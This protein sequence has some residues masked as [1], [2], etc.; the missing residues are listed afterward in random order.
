MAPRYAWPLFGLASLPA[1]LPEATAAARVLLSSGA[2]YL[3]DEVS[4]WP[5]EEPPWV[6]MAVVGRSNVGKSSLL[7][8]LLGS[9]DNKFVPVS[10]HPGSTRH[11][12]FYGVGASG[13]APPPFVFVDSP[14]YGYNSHGK[15]AQ[16]AWFDLIAAYL[17]RRNPAILPRTLLLLDASVGC[18]PTDAAVLQLFDGACAPYH[19]V[20]TK[21][22]TV[23]PAHLEATVATLA[24][25]LARRA[26]P[27]P[28]IN[29]VSTRTGAGMSTLKEHLMMSAKVYRRPDVA[30]TLAAA[31][32]QL[33][34]ARKH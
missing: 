9:R 18:T 12:D 3:G 4:H 5:T 31:T 1:V 23:T 32:R 2:R 19:V 20:L 13:S 27:F 11:L 8:A 22:D 10:R 7:N 29:A 6:E 15:R 30:A 28:I 25:R 17:R 33:A 16:D 14:G 21:A 24:A 26:L 34:G